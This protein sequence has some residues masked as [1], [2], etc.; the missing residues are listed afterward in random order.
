[1]RTLNQISLLAVLCLLGSAAAHHHGG[2]FFVE[3]IAGLPELSCAACYRSQPNAPNSVGCGH[4]SSDQDKCMIYEYFKFP[5]KDLCG[6]CVENYA[7]DVKTF[8]CIPGKIKGCNAEYLYPDG[9]KCFSCTNGYAE[10]LQDGTYKCVP[11]SQVNNPIANCL[12]GGLYDKKAQPQVRYCS[13]CQTGYSATFDGKKCEKAKFPGCHRNTADGTRC[14][15]CDVFDGFSQ[16]PDYSCL[17]VG[18]DGVLPKT[19]E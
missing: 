17:K 10:L 6:R 18:A 2:C 11:P 16:Q 14:A 9:R 13:R 1:M 5:K 19:Q 15:E 7:L 8:K 12:Q 4:P 3:K